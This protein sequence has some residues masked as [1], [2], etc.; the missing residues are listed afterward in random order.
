MN[1]FVMLVDFKNESVIYMIGSE[2]LDIHSSKHKQKDDCKE[3]LED[4]NT[5]VKFIQVIYIR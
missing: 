4:H 1:K 3:K 5:R 2:N